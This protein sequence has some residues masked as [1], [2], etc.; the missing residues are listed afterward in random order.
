[1]PQRTP[2]H[3]APRDYNPEVIQGVTWVIGALALVLLV[4]E[5]TVLGAAVRS[6]STFQAT[7]LTIVV[8]AVGTWL[9]RNGR[10]MLAAHLLISAVFLVAWFFTYQV[11][12][13][14]GDAV[15]FLGLV[16]APLV[17]S[18]LVRPSW[19]AVYAVGNL[20]GILGIGALPG[21]AAAATLDTL[22]FAVA[23]G[24]LATFASYQRTRSLAEA[25]DQ[26]DAASRRKREMDAMIGSSQDAQVFFD[27]NGNILQLN[28]RFADLFGIGSQRRAGPIDALLPNRLL[29]GFNEAVAASREGPVT[30]EFALESASGALMDIEATVVSVDHGGDAP[31]VLLSCRDITA[32][33]RAIQD[34]ERA[35]NE[36]RTGLLN[37]IS[38]HLRTPL[39]PMRMDLYT[40]MHGAREALTEKQVAALE[41]M[42]REFTRLTGTLD[43]MVDASRLSRAGT[44]A[45]QPCSLR[46]A[47]NEAFTVAKKQ[48]ERHN[49]VS[50]DAIAL[51]EP[52]VLRVVLRL[53]ASW[54]DPALDW[55]AFAMATASDV[56][57][58]LAAG[59]SSP[60]DERLQVHETLSQHSDDDVFAENMVLFVANNA[61]D[62]TGGRLQAYTGPKGHRIES[63]L[64]RG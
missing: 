50:A 51:A 38:H 52:S 61:V 5:I 25:F 22:T 30:W 45:R 6:S 13:A 63:T 9:C 7:L 32:R 23:F 41:R 12:V 59:E 64:P 11:W 18:I 58:V 49:D 39:T 62:A 31:Y 56:K 34:R 42:E 1:M 43:L 53:L 21:A 46:D 44:E 2:A 16:Y 4:V 17:A 36:A 57:L 33:K 28:T 48:G 37:L 8:A 15:V 3:G 29:D 14:E 24:A 20:V 54:L 26:R 27:G 47:V 60:D 40:L 19:V 10:A 35:V 55:R